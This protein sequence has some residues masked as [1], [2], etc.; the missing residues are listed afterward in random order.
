M[1]QLNEAG[2]NRGDLNYLVLPLVEIDTFESKISNSKAVVI[3]F[4]LFDKDPAKDVEHFIEKGAIEVLDAETSPAP[5]EDGYYVVFIELDRDEQLPEKLVKI[6]DSI[7]N[8]TNI[9]EWQFKTLH[10]D[11]IYPLT[12][13]NIKEHVNLDPAMVPPSE[14]DLK[15]EA[16]EELEDKVDAEEKKAEAEEEELAETLVPI[17][18]NGLMESVELYDNTLRLSGPGINLV[19]K[20]VYA[21]KDQ[22]SMPILAPG[23]GHPAI[24][25]S[26]KLARVLG[27][28][29]SVEIVDEGL[30]VSNENGCMLLSLL[31]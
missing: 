29:Y 9:D 1:T 6:V 16:E 14:E 30:L 11:N 2:L 23:I 26:A 19:Y 31:D 25:E 20:V 24:N 28:D 5:T 10:D 3:A 7:N 8:I 17:L 22:P 15:D 21:S 18:K 27:P 12:E 4:Y 13:D